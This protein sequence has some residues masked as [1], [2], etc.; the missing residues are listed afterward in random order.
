[1]KRHS[2]DNRVIIKLYPD[3]LSSA[4]HRTEKWSYEPF[5]DVSAMILTLCTPLPQSTAADSL[6]TS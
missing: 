1:M 5:N 4:D 6:S 3:R 2:D